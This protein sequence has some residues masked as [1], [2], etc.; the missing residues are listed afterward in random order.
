[1]A[2]DI[3]NEKHICKFLKQSF[4]LPLNLIYKSHNYYY[5][6]LV[7]NLPILNLQVLDLIVL[8][9]HGR[10][11]QFLDLPSLNLQVLNLPVVNLQDRN[12]LVL[13]L[14]TL[15]L[16]V[17]NLQ[18]PIDQSEVVIIEFPT[19][20]ASRPPIKFASTLILINTHDHILL[21]FV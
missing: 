18:V 20:F 9:L 11:L 2:S 1:M 21:V 5:L 3:L 4:H 19:I 13:N 16:P 8:N 7:L 14:L 17:L 12:L 10:N 15:N 6:L